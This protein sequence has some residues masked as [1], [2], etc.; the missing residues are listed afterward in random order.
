LSASR[1]HSD[2]I[3]TKWNRKKNKIGPGRRT[4]PRVPSHLMDIVFHDTDPNGNTLNRRNSRNGIDIEKES[5]QS[6]VKD[7]ISARHVLPISFKC[8]DMQ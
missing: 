6:T 3:A 7:E 4:R 5:S 8:R 1:R 2:A